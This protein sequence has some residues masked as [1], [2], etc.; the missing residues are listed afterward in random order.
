MIVI[1]PYYKRI[2]PVTIYV[3]IGLFKI[4]SLER[5]YRNNLKIREI[6]RIVIK[7]RLWNHSRTNYQCHRIYAN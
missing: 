5:T 6:T 3:N 4:F 1:L 2:S 7:R